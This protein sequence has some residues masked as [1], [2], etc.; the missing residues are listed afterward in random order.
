MGGQTARKPPTDIWNTPA[1]R[2]FDLAN[3][4]RQFMPDSYFG[5][6]SIS[7]PSAILSA[8]TRNLPAFLNSSRLP[9]EPPP[10][11][12]QAAMDAAAAKARAARNRGMGLPGLPGMGG[13]LPGMGGQRLPGMPSA[14]GMLFGIPGLF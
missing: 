2:P 3:T 6:E 14:S 11:L 5:N 9:T 1:D 10:T 4:Q 13:G 12:N 7:D 8:Y